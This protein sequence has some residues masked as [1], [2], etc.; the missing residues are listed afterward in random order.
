MVRA[1]ASHQCGPGSIPSLSVICGLSLLLVL[2]PALRVFLRVLWFSSLH[3][4]QHFQIPIQPGNSGEKSHSVDSHEI[5][6]YF[7]YLF[8]YLFIYFWSLKISQ[9]FC[10]PFPH[11]SRKMSFSK[12]VYFQTFPDWCMEPNLV[13]AKGVVGTGFWPKIRTWLIVLTTNR[14]KALFLGE[15]LHKFFFFFF[16]F[17][18][19][20]KSLAC[21]TIPSPIFSNLFV[22]RVHLTLSFCEF[23]AVYITVD[24]CT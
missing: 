24:N 20:L 17:I 15:H 18:S 9:K 3:K 11:C 6:I 10:F 12:K 2:V 4:N 22:Q 7:I 21:Q 23:C 5:P 8:I 14:W 16:L 13:N 1:L 19:V